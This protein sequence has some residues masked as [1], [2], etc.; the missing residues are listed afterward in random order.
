MNNTLNILVIGAHPDD[1]EIQAG[2][3]SLLYASAGHH[4]AFVS[5]T[6]GD[7]GHFR[8]SGSALAAR[9]TRE[10]QRAAQIGGI[11]SIVLDIHDGELEPTVE[12][13]R[14]LIRLI[15]SLKPDLIITHRSNDYHP[16]HRYTSILVQDAA[17]LITVAN[18]CPE[19][20]S[21]SV[22]PV[23]LYMSDRFR[24]PAPFQPTIAVGIDAVVS[25][26]LEML[27]CHE[28][29]VYEFMPFSHGHLHEVPK[30]EKGRVDW[31]VRRWLP[32]SSADPWREVLK[33]LYG[34][35][36]GNE[37]RYAEA[38]EASEYGAPLNAETAK[39]LFSA[40]FEYTDACVGR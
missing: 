5:V 33:I 26:K 29:Q 25:R 36:K 20:P 23:I 30:D 35:Q 3:I 31:L 11:E 19:S 13:R 8:E 4:V 38:F 40:F 17:F 6:N 28:S 10:S 14:K 32:E 15:R 21:M 34:H 2:G 12:N 22:M 1:A 27:H 9:R 7:A 16:D 18:I 37:I 39:R 24:K